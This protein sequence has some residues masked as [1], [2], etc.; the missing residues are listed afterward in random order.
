[1]NGINNPGKMFSTVHNM[2]STD[3]DLFQEILNAERQLDAAGVSMIRTAVP[4][5]MQ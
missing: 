5:S 1:M 2:R 4:I 3:D